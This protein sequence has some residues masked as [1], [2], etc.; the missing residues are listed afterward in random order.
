MYVGTHVSYNREADTSLISISVCISI[1]ERHP[2]N[3]T[4]YYQGN[5][6]KKTLFGCYRT[7][8]FTRSILCAYGPYEFVLCQGTCLVAL[9]S[10]GLYGF[11]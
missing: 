11:V 9:L 4:S 3:D 2:L 5:L 7:N 8:N 6:L 10:N 1:Y